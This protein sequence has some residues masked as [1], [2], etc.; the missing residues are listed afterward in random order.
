[1]LAKWWKEILK[2]KLQ[3]AFP[4]TEHIGGEIT[5]GPAYNEFGYNEHPAT[6]S[7]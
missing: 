3:A 6:T 5:L 7:R 4:F 2:I 1:M